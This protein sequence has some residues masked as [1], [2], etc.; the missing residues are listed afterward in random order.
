MSPPTL[1]DVQMTSSL[2]KLGGLLLTSLVL[3]LGCANRPA[4]PVEAEVIR[5]VPQKLALIAVMEPPRLTIENRGS[6]WGVLALPGVFIQR[7]IESG[8][9]DSLT[10]AM[11][12][13]GLHLGEEMTAAF[14]EELKRLGYTVEVIRN[15]KRPK[16]DPESV[17]FES[18]ET[19]ADAIVTVR[20]FGAGLYA[21]QFST[22]YLPRLNVDIDVVSKADQSELHSQSIYYGADAR[23]RLDDQIPAAPQYAYASYDQVWDKQREVSEGFRHGVQ[24]IAAQAAR[25]LQ[26]VG[27]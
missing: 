10:Q 9:A 20:Y 24:Q 26:K 7:S 4:Q 13:Q 1:A 25:Q 2:A 18:I 12:A 22:S 15:V 19:D 6:A 16:D 8:R 27:R 3:L 23:E 5:P 11:R 14:G 21:G 17:V